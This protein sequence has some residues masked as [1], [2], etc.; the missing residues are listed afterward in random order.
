GRV[1]EPKMAAALLA[2]M[3]ARIAA[4]AVH[5]RAVVGEVL[6]SGDLQALRR[7]HEVDRVA[8]AARRL[9][10]DRAVAEVERVGRVAL[11]REAHRAAMAGALELHGCPRVR[12]L[13]A[14]AATSGARS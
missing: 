6:A 1:P 12:S 11:C 5:A 13:I 4:A 8:A 14:A 3:P 2:E 7:A 10:A 9:V